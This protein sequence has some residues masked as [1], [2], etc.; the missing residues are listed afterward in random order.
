MTCGGGGRSELS[1]GELET[2]DLGLAWPQC[3]HQQPGEYNYGLHTSSV[4]PLTTLTTLT[5]ARDLTNSSIKL[6]LIKPA[7]SQQ[8]SQQP[9]EKSNANSRF[10]MRR[11]VCYC[12]VL[13]VIPPP[14][15]PPP[16]SACRKMWGLNRFLLC[17][18]AS[19]PSPAQPGP[20]GLQWW[21]G[22]QQS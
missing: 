12:K 11:D 14:L 1:G 13:L 6:S 20:P 2:G 18:P 21:Q 16:C 5:T 4:T 22:S 9:A 3:Q 10:F 7:F 19:L 17:S 15:P 8:T